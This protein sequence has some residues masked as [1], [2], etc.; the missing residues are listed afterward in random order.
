MKISYIWIKEYK[1]IK[2][3]HFN[4][5]EKWNFHF[6][7]KIGRLSVNK[8]KESLNI[9]SSENLNITAI[10][11]K[12]GSGKSSFIEALV[13]NK[14]IE[15]LIVVGN[16]ILLHPLSEF[17]FTENDFPINVNLKEL[18]SRTSKTF[19]TK[20]EEFDELIKTNSDNIVSIDF[21]FAGSD[22]KIIQINKFESKKYFEN[23]IY[24][25]P[26]FNY[27]FQP[28]ENINNI[29][30]SYC[31]KNDKNSYLNTNTDNDSSFTSEIKAN[32]FTTLNRQIKFLNQH[33]DANIPIP[34]AKKIIVQFSDFENE[35]LAEGKNGENFKKIKNQLKNIEL[36]MDSIFTDIEEFIENIARL[37]I[38]SLIITD[39]FR[40]DEITKKENETWENALHS[41]LCT[42]FNTDT[43]T[44][45]TNIFGE[46]KTAIEEFFKHIRNSKEKVIYNQS[47]P[48]YMI[49]NIE[50]NEEFT[51]DFIRKYNE[52]SFTGNFL[53][54]NW[55]YNYSSGEKAFLNLYALFNEVKEKQGSKDYVLIM[56]EGETYFHPNWQ[57]QFIS[58]LIELKKL[59]LPDNK[60][61][62][63]L[64]T[65]S[66]FIMS[67][68]PKENIVFLDTYDENDSE[69]KGKRQ[70]NGN[71]KVVKNAI[72]KNTFGANIHSLLSDGFFM[73]SLIGIYA[74]TEINKA[75]KFL[76][77]DE[78]NE[79]N[80]MKTKQLIEVIGEPIVKEHLAKMYD[81][82]F[83]SE[84]ELEILDK[85]IE[86]LQ[87]KKNRYND[88]N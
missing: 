28:S 6:D 86:R 46:R 73:D 35:L 34:K 17:K 49:L 71:C 1:N 12:N 60:I 9:F 21:K 79:E 31:L 75:F 85:E 66:P 23:I 72:E 16:T 45:K 8:R 56:D 87:E 58:A 37:E 10:V 76:N 5:N 67:D 18:L 14:N 53:S 22:M 42:D 61:Q 27:E 59:L 69:V 54:F 70:A 13:S 50:E 77:S 51:Q 15:K 26:F 43:L 25:S 52:C 62:L 24:Y 57:K 48:S 3:Q 38:Y 41:Y 7:E 68:L 30:F 64:T 39:A 36:S 55:N 11:G 29:S 20:T 74:K 78:N 84:L 81:K 47:S 65:H 63:I 19:N 83:S 88:K 4:F 82:K 40:L 2:D 33:K 32:H 44:I 80:K